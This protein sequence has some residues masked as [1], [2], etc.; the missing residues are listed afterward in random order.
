MGAVLTQRPD[1]FRAV[2]SG[3][4]L[5]DMLRSET[6]QNGQYNMTEYGSVKDAEQFKALRAYSPF[7]NVKDGVHYPAVMLMVGENDPRVDPWHSR[8]FA[9][10]LQAATASKYPILLISFSNAGHGG[11]GSSEDQQLAMSTY[12]LEFLYDQLGVTWV[13][14]PTSH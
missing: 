6:T 13:T 9:A 5:Y 10:A 8:K 2:F 14:P 1:L 3:A 11:I 7:H 4:G 12:G